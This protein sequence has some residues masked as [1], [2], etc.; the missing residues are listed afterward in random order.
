MAARVVDFPQ[1]VTPQTMTRPSW[2]AWVI[3]S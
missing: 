2:V 1:P 3:F